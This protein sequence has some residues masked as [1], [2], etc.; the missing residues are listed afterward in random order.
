MYD[1]EEEIDVLE[2]AL[3][4]LSSALEECLESPYHKY[5]ANS[6]EVD[7]DEIKARLEELYEI[8]NSYWAAEN[9]QQISEY[10]GE[11]L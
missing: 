6:L 11:V 9:K 2:S 8:Q 4:H 5:L 10:W 1:I 3:S 7:I